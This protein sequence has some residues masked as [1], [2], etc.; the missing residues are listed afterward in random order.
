MRKSDVKS[1]S[2]LAGQVERLVM[3]RSSDRLTD[4]FQRSTRCKI[5]VSVRFEVTASSATKYC[6]GDYRSFINLCP[7]PGLPWRSLIPVADMIASKRLIYDETPDHLPLT[8][9]TT[10]RRLSHWSAFRK[11]ESRQQYAQPHNLNSLARVITVNIAPC[12]SYPGGNRSHW[13]ALCLS[14]P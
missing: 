13:A 2:K 8:F 7:G 10:R 9:R 12:A 14:C 5:I 6:H 4:D 3:W 11:E 1:Q